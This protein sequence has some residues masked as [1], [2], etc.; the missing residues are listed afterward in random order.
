MDTIAWTVIGAAIAILVAVGSAF[1]RLCDELRRTIACAF[2]L[3]LAAL[4]TQCAHG[5]PTSGQAPVRMGTLEDSSE[6]GTA[7]PR[8]PGEVFEDCDVCP[9][10]VVLPGG[11]S[12]LGRYEVTVGEYRAFA[13]ATG[14]GM[15]ACDRGGRHTWRERGFLGQTDRHPVVCVS[16]DDAQA[17]V[18]WVSGRTDVA[19]R[20]PGEAEWDGAAA[21]SPPGCYYQRTGNLG[22]CP[23]GHSGSNGL[24]LSD[25]AG[26]AW[27]WTD[28][29]WAG[30]CGRRVLKGGAWNTQTGYPISRLRRPGVRT[31]APLA[32]R[33]YGIGFRVSRLLD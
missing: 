21:G 13:A 22:T 16:W 1:R 23:V 14:G 33:S 6:P 4:L 17:Y 29:C 15:P 7:A 19:Y 20:L 26:N 5:Q 31:S 2:T 25:M 28:D 9:E 32:R 18:S 3:A 10:M 24:G 30:D 8:R 11:R 27:E 12:A